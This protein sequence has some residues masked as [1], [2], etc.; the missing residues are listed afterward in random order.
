[1]TEICSMYA[2][3]GLSILSCHVGSS[4][5]A[6]LA[7][8]AATLAWCSVWKNTHELVSFSSLCHFCCGLTNSCFV[9]FRIE[10]RVSHHQPP[11]KSRLGQGQEGSSIKTQIDI[12]FYKAKKV[13]KRS[14]SLLFNFWMTQN[15][16]CRPCKVLCH[17]L[18]FLLSLHGV[19]LVD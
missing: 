17:V 7:L 1:M 4:T 13:S 14:C 11:S 18:R 10:T 3:M 16:L 9:I 6:L 15:K 19:I 8:V 5:S 12:L 2:R